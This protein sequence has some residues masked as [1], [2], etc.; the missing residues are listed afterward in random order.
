MKMSKTLHTVWTII[1]LALLG[2]MT[3]SG[4]ASDTALAQ[5]KHSSIVRIANTV[6]LPATRAVKVG[7]NKSAVVELPRDI[8][9][10]LASDPKILDVVVNNSRRVYLI[11]TGIGQAN[12]F[13]FDTKGTR[14]LTLE[15]VVDRDPAPLERLLNR[16]INN[17]K[18][19]VE[20]INDTVVLTG[21]VPHASDASRASDI[22]SRFMVTDDP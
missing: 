10:V 15:V 21:K 4:L 5:S 8:R 6:K 19:T 17:A 20:F 22:A 16:L 1:A 18:I 7:L 13:F 3:L 2:C 14:I 9:D 12:V 11:G